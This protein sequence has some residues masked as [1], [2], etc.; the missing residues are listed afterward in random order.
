MVVSNYTKL[1]SWVSQ[2]TARSAH[3]AADRE[4]AGNAAT[5]G[6][7]WIR[8]LWSIVWTCAVFSALS[9]I[10]H[11]YYS[12]FLMND[13]EEQVKIAR[14][15]CKE[16][17][18]NWPRSSKL[19]I[20]K[21]AL[22]VQEVTRL[23][24]ALHTAKAEKVEAE[25]NCS[26]YEQKLNEAEHKMAQVTA[27]LDSVQNSTAEKFILATKSTYLSLCPEGDFDRIF[28]SLAEPSTAPT[29]SPGTGPITSIAKRRKVTP[30]L[31]QSM[32]LVEARTNKCRSIWIP[33]LICFCQWRMF[34][35]EPLFSLWRLTIA[36]HVS[37]ICCDA[38]YVSAIH[39]RLLAVSFPISKLGLAGWLLVW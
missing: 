33:L 25:R 20:K 32:M 28:Q 11:Y 29:S 4:S 19:R 1:I 27:E 3:W 38:E 36:V 24:A 22:L 26:H 7:L 13:F 21:N 12:I 35:S 17:T 16:I 8:A 9:N 31:L 23:N 18:R 37:S 6:F 15:F 39:H 2:Q 34:V 5:K 14:S 10:L 30:E